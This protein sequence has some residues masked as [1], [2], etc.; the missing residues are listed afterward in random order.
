[1]EKT[2]VLK[3]ELDNENLSEILD[4][5]VNELKEDELPAIFDRACPN[6]DWRISSYRLN[7]GLACIE[8][9]EEQSL[10]ND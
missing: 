7:K 10:A 5:S 1:M 2:K 9:I 4:R 8:C 6:C 3:A